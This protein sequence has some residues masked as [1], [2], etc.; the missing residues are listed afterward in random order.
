MHLYFKALQIVTYKIGHYK[1]QYLERV[2]CNLIK[3]I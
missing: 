1:R 2:Q 3:H